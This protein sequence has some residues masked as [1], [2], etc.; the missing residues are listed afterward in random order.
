[1][2]KS[3][4]ILLFPCLLLS[5]SCQAQVAPVKEIRFPNGKICL[6]LDSINAGKAITTDR[7]DGY[8][9][10]VN[11]SEMSIQMHQPID[12]GKTRATVL[13]EYIQY[14]KTD[15]EGFTAEEEG[16]VGHP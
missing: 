16:T 11:V 1:M 6:L 8:F 7:N 10:K 14:L 5:F 2:L 3:T 4:Q 13:Q 12:P 15:V 9:D